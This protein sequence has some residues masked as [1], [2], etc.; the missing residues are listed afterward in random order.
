VIENLG[1]NCKS[2][3]VYILSNSQTVIKA[4]SSYW[5][6][7]KLVSNSYQSLMQVAE[8]N[9]VQLIWEPGHLGID[10]NDMADQLA[11]LNKFAASQW[12][13]PR[14]GQGRDNQR[15]QETLRFL[16]LTLSS[17]GTHTGVL[18]QENKGAFKLEQKPAMMGGRTTHRALSPSV[19]GVKRKKNQPHILL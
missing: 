11:K 19:K 13:L 2:R 14:S 8:H 7:S 18:C 5:I 6:T 15:P 1:R 10:G 12:E 3:N 4:L 17:K 9:R 16:K